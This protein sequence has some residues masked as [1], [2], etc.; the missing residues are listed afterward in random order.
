MADRIAHQLHGDMV[1]FLAQ[2][3]ALAD[4]LGILC[5]SLK[6][7]GFRDTYLVQVLGPDRGAMAL[8]ALEDIFGIWGPE[9]KPR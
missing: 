3:N 2:R 9:G 6:V 1:T 4:L 7:P 8:R 5:P